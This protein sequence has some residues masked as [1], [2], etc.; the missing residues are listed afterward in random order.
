M[1]E[2]NEEATAGAETAETASTISAGSSRA[3]SKGPPKSIGRQSTGRPNQFRGNV[4]AMNGIVFQLH[5]ERSKKGQ[6]RDSLEALKTMA[7]T[8][9]KQEVR[10]LEPLFRELKDPVV[11]LP[12]KPRKEEFPDPDDSTKTIMEINPVKLDIY[13]EEIKEFV[14]KEDRL[15]QTKSALVNIVTA[16]CSKPMRN[17]LK[18]TKG[19]DKMEQEGDIAGL[20]R[21]IRDLSNQIEENVSPYETMDELH[22]QFFWYRQ[23]YG[24]DNSTHLTEF[25]ELVDVLEHNGSSIF[26]DQGLI[27]HEIEATGASTKEEIKKCEKTARDKHLATGFLR[28]ANQSIYT[29]L[30]RELRDQR[31]HGHDPYPSNLAD[32]YTLLENHSSN[33]RRSGPGNEG[34]R[35][36]GGVVQDIQ[37]A[38]QGE[39]EKNP[40]GPIAGVDG[41]FIPY[42]RCYACKRMGHYADN[43]PAGSNTEGQQYHM[44]AAVIEENSDWDS[45]EDSLVISFTY[46]TNRERVKPDRTKVLIDTGS[47]CSVFNNI[48][49]LENVRKSKHKLKAYTNGG[50]HESEYKGFLPGFFEVWYNPNSMINILSFNDVSEKFRITMDTAEENA[51][52]VHVDEENGRVMRFKSID[53]GLYI[54]DAND[55]DFVNHYSYLN[56]END[57]AIEYYSRREI[58]KADEAR[59]L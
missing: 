38:Q 14:K 4:T 31:L 41:R 25:K 50:S 36:Q 2:H 45:D 20:L 5:S 3:T 26:K 43:C 11:A 22:K 46:L 8:E 47:N 17:K 59:R 28:R 48:E 16:Q 52:L 27:K 35:N 55:N 37:H 1:K 49:M 40:E 33:K 13:G 9:F 24:E 19:Y 12:V 34:N 58:D 53:A 23:N 18:G 7:A 57:N 21:T 32:A 29:P 51:I 6:F 15:K 39:K 30:L 10:F 56:V 42:R 44:H 54:L